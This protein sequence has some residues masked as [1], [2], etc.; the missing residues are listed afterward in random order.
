MGRLARMVALELFHH[1]TQRGNRRLPT[2]FQENDYRL[3][4]TLLAEGCRCC[5]VQLWSSAAAHLG[6]HDPTGLLDMLAWQATH[7][8]PVWQEALAS[9][10]DD[11]VLTRLRTTTHAS[12]PLGAESSARNWKLCWTAAFTPF[13]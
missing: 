10:E 11:E 4:L 3:Y 1:V 5:A 8:L 2:F 7:P 13:R 12:R 9:P 6:Q